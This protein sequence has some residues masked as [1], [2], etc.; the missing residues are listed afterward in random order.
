MTYHIWRR[1]GWDAPFPIAPG[2]RA[3]VFP[4]SVVG[5]RR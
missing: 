3:H 1:G 5:T 4:A 2:A